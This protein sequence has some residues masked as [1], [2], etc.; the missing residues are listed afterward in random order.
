MVETMVLG[1][2][3]R[4]GHGLR[5]GVAE[6]LVDPS[7]VE[8]PA[9]GEPDRKKVD[10]GFV[11][12]AVPFGVPSAIA[13]IGGPAIDVEQRPEQVVLIGA[14]GNAEPRE[15]R[16]DGFDGIVGKRRH[17]GAKAGDA[18][19]FGI[20]V[21]A[22]QPAP[23]RVRAHRAHRKRPNRLPLVEI[24]RAEAR[25][26]LDHEFDQRDMPVALGAAVENLG[27][28]RNHRGRLFHRAGSQRSALE[29]AQSHALH[30]MS[31]HRRRQRR[32]VDLARS[33]GLRIEGAR[34]Q[35]RRARHAV[36]RRAGLRKALFG[37]TEERI[38]R[39][40]M[41]E[42]PERGHALASRS[43]GRAKIGL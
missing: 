23:R 27:D 16:I 35:H 12:A 34:H 21:V 24:G 7:V 42:R 43:H 41:L 31:A 4:I 37:K 28:G 3:G 2:A 33:D 32:V 25:D 10:Q 36:E 13:R 39:D 17:A 9:P 11:G 19:N 6:P 40:E 22:R 38:D 14:R 20:A 8:R 15:D 18:H 26:L 5:P 29:R 30:A 1:Q